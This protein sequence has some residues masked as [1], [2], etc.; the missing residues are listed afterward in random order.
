MHTFVAKCRCVG[1]LAGF[2][3]LDVLLMRHNFFNLLNSSISGSHMIRGDAI[4]NDVHLLD[5][6]WIV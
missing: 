6:L 3:A 5:L 4:C 1:N 2:E